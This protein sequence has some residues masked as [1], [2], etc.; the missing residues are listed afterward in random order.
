MATPVYLSF[1][2]GLNRDVSQPV[3]KPSEFVMLLNA[4][5][6]KVGSKTK[7]LG[8]TKFLDNPDNG[9]VDKII[10]W[11][12][13]GVQKKLLF[14]VSGGNIYCYNVMTGDGLHW[15]TPI[16][17]GLSLVSRLSV[18]VLSGKMFF[19]NGQN[20]MFYTSDGVT[21][22]D[23]PTTSTSVPPRCKYLAVY[24]SRLY[25]AGS[26]N[27]L[28]GQT[29]GTGPSSLYWSTVN[30]GTDWTI[31]LAD[32]STAG[33]KYVDPDY[34][35]VIN[36]LNK[37]YN[38]LLVFKEG[39]SYRFQS[40]NLSWSVEDLNLITT[41]SN[42][43]VDSYKDY[44]FWLNT[45]GIWGYSGS[46]PD[47]LSS[48]LD[49]VIDNISGQDIAD[50]QGKVY[51]KH[52]YCSIGDMQLDDLSLKNMIVDLDFDK[53][54]FYTHTFANKPTAWG[55]YIDKN[56]DSQLLFGD[57]KGN[58]FT[59]FTGN[60]DNGIPIS[61]ILRTPVFDEGAPEIDKKYNKMY[62]E[63]SPYDSCE[64]KV[65]IDGGEWIS[66][67]DLYSPIT[68]NY[69]SPKNT[70]SYSRNIQ[71]QISDTSLDGRPELRRLIYYYEVFGG[72][73]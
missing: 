45:D 68:K 6:E 30:D 5:S 8:Y 12:N 13:L 3:M 11:N 63:A 43:S 15:G 29:S 23:V 32:P 4:T 47:I 70:G 72:N 7:R 51:K 36:G 62:V 66:V 9:K 55:D 54:Q 38:R 64:S 48:P 65:S 71:F 2:E 61:M 33:Y 14:R 67:G 53:S 26:T 24:L 25:A 17:T 27:E 1:F 60:N 22:T 19:S 50:A 35:G 16:K 44:T 40:N 41:T 69:F 52:Y 73:K 42:G 34:N 56:G 49:D 21:C 31:D 18:A 57:D 20:A 58:T 39:A 10:Y 28:S 46:T 59:M 37:A